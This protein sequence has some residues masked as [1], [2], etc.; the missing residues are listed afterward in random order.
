MK[1]AE[2]ENDEIV[3]NFVFNVVD[4]IKKNIQDDGVCFITIPPNQL[5]CQLTGGNAGGPLVLTGS[6][7]N[8]V[9][10][11]GIIR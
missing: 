8:Y 9:F 3:K 1:Y 5:M 4:M 2:N 11:W 7:K 10:V 6:N